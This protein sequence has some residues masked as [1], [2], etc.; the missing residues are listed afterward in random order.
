[1]KLDFSKLKNIAYRG[2]EGEKARAEKDAL[3]A[4]GFTVI[5]GETTPFEYPPNQDAGG[6]TRSAG[7]PLERKL[8]PIAGAGKSFS[9]R[10][11][12]WAACAF[13]ECHSPPTVDYEYWRTHTSGTDETPQ[14]ELD[15]WN[16][17]ARDI[18]AEVERHGRDPFFV[19]LLE[20]V[21]AELA[22]EYERERNKAATPF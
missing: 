8:K 14:A 20:T 7:S 6:S 5:E 15:Y 16:Q 19:S 22:R 12:Y 17:T 18:Q 13:H 10:E 3:I 4:Q 9:Y 2:F 1:M 21:H 11:M